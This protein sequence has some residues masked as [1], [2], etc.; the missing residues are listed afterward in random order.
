MGPDAAR[1]A[2]QADR[3][4]GFAELV[5]LVARFSKLTFIFVVVS[6]LFYSVLTARELV[7]FMKALEYMLREEDEWTAHTDVET[8]RHFMNYW[9]AFFPVAVCGTLFLAA[10][11]VCGYIGSR[12]LHSPCLGCFTMCSCIYGTFSIVGFF[13][14]AAVIGSVVGSIPQL[15]GYLQDCNPDVCLSMS[16]SKKIDCFA[17]TLPWYRVRYRHIP[18]LPD[19]CP[20]VFLLCAEF[21]PTGPPRWPPERVNLPYIVEGPDV[22]ETPM[23]ELLDSLS[24]AHP[25][26]PHFW[27]EINERTCVVDYHWVRVFKDSQ[28]LVHVAAPSFIASLCAYM[29]VL[30][31]MS[32]LSCAGS[33]YGKELLRRL[34][35]LDNFYGDDDLRGHFAAHGQEIPGLNAASRI[36]SYNEQAI[37]RMA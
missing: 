10:V 28:E 31:P 21:P 6:A 17:A 23:D 12:R 25:P 27:K 34:T 14:L 8:P 13:W 4:R 5:K 37:S 24:V 3:Q 15:E 16:P 20:R 35:S 1:V 26:S 30:I 9:V 29:V 2:I 7:N 11:P 18:H 32:F 36:S 19:G 22:E 33:W